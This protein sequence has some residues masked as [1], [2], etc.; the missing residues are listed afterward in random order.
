[1][2]GY[3]TPI[4]HNIPVHTTIYLLVHLVTILREV[5]VLIVTDCCTFANSLI[6]RTYTLFFQKR[7]IVRIVNQ[8]MVQMYKAVHTGTD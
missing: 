8:I 6:L 7:E 5:V 2:L 1:M 4:Y 3:D